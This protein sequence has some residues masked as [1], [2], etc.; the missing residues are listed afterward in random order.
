[1]YAGGSNDTFFYDYEQSRRMLQLRIKLDS[2]SQGVPEFIRARNRV[3]LI[4][5]YMRLPPARVWLYSLSV[6]L[7]ILYHNEEVDVREELSSGRRPLDSPENII[8][9][10]KYLT[11]LMSAL[12]LLTGTT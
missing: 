9:E 7:M 3:L 1:M 10:G 5:T 11:E 8:A 4:D 6:K 2:W 12:R